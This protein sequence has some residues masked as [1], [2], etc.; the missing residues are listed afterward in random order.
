MAASSHGGG[1][2]TEALIPA[3]VS[4]RFVGPSLLGGS[5]GVVKWRIEEEHYEPGFHLETYVRS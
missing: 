2:P 5:R 1:K 4:S 3:R